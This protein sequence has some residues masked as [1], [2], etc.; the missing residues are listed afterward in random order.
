MKQAL[1]IFR[2]DVRRLWPLIALV[3]A[4]F[5]TAAGDW[6]PLTGPARNGVVVG[7]GASF[8]YVDV[9]L[10]PLL[11]HLPLLSIPA[12][13]ILAA[14][15]VHQEALPGDHQFWLTRPYERLSL[16][17]AKML[18][19]SVFVFLPHV[20]IGGLGEAHMGVPVLPNIGRLL[21]WGIMSSMWLI[22]PGIAI[23]VVTS[24]LAGFVGVLL[25]VS[26][27][28]GVYGIYGSVEQWF[29]TAVA[30]PG[31]TNL[32]GYLP[33]IALAIGAIVLQY[34][35][36][37]T[38]WS[39]GLLA[40]G[41]LA[42]ALTLPADSLVSL[43]TRLRNPGFDPA[44]VHIAFDESSPLRLERTHFPHRTCQSLRLNVDGLPRGAAL[45]TFG[46]SALEIEPRTPGRKI[47]LSGD[48]AGLEEFGDGF[49]KVFCLDD[50]VYAALK[51][52]TV[53]LRLSIRATVRSTVDEIRV[54]FKGGH[55]IAAGS[56]GH[57]DWPFEIGIPCRLAMP[58]S[59]SLNAGVEYE[60]YKIYSTKFAAN[61]YS[62]PFSESRPGS[63]ELFE[64][65]PP[66]MAIVTQMTD[67]WSRPGAT[68]VLRR[69]RAIGYIER[70][71]VYYGLRLAEAA[72]R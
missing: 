65:S 35:R 45:E 54:P 7:G 2:K 20:I 27:T 60:G 11:A 69:Q 40:A 52:D 64:F 30:A 31:I 12:C 53:T 22:L 4:L 70:D 67:V 24:S 16:L 23:G 33:M 6:I 18:F 19:L 10:A 50:S 58:L 47:T 41:L 38:A 68:L 46:N 29:G 72:S 36:R 61:Q 3:L 44:R 56:A 28:A 39:I 59:D 21:G 42:P 26:L 62:S 34:H 15:A 57:C 48:Q 17:T 13:W 49:R 51:D 66:G 37:K 14:R 32:A 9:G 63:A 5:A 71:L 1:H 8:G 43:A 25:A 55:D